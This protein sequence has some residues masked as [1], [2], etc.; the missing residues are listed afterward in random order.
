MGNHAVCTINIKDEKYGVDGIYILDP[1]GDCNPHKDYSNLD[2][3][4]F[5]LTEN[6]YN[7]MKPNNK[8][9]NF[10]DKIGQE[11]YSF[12]I[13][14]SVLLYFNEFVNSRS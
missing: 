1:T 4:Y 12:H 2:F 10:S 8:F 7:L 13:S 9:D 6:E 5:L 3:N 14:L 11:E